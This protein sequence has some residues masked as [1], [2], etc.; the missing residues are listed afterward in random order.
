MVFIMS[1]QCHMGAEM[2]ALTWAAPTKAR[3]GKA[4]GGGVSW[5]SCFTWEWGRGVWGSMS[6]SSDLAWYP[7]RKGRKCVG[8]RTGLGPF[9]PL[10][11]WEGGT[12]NRAFWNPVRGQLGKLEKLSFKSH[13]QFPDSHEVEIWVYTAFVPNNPSLAI[14]TENKTHLVCP[15]ELT[16]FNTYLCPA[17]N[18]AGLCSFIVMKPWDR[19]SH[20]SKDQRYLG[21]QG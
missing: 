2:L 13:K 7:S 12:V 1:R 9:L 16:Y 10:S 5:L 17:L 18:L 15:S 8:K 19:N 11:P 20:S 4:T 6:G 14:K 21:T 3:P